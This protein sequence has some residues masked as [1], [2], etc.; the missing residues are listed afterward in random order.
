M[1]KYSVD[2]EQLEA[3]RNGEMQLPN[4][5]KLKQAEDRIAGKKQFEM[6]AIKEDEADRSY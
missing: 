6:Q 1:R 2:Q 4:L 5:K 3:I